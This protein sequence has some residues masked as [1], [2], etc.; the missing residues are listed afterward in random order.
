L[1]T[2]S[3]KF[4]AEFDC[5][6]DQFL[7]F[8]NE[9]LMQ[10]YERNIVVAIDE[11]E[12]SDKELD[13]FGSLLDQP[14][15]L[16]MMT[17][18]K[19][20]IQKVSSSWEASLGY[21]EGEMVGK[22]F[23]EFVHP[24]DIK[25][26]KHEVNLLAQGKSTLLFENR[27]I[28]KNGEELTLQ[29]AVIAVISEELV[30][31]FATD[32][33]ELKNTRNSMRRAIKL[34]EHSQVAAKVGGWELDIASGDLYWTDET[35]RIHDTSPEEFNP[36]VDAGVSYF[37]P[38]SKRIIS[39]AIQVAMESGVGYQ[40]DLQTYTTKGRLIDVY[41]TC[42]VTLENGR[43]SK[44][45][46]IFQDIT[47]RTKARTKLAKERSRLSAIF[48]SA[49]DG[50]ILIDSAGIVLSFN[51]AAES[52][53]KRTAEDVVGANVSLLM[54]DSI[55]GQHDGFLSNYLAGGAPGIIG[56]GREVIAQRSDG[57]HFPIELSITEWF[58]GEQRMFTGTVRDLSERKRIQSQLIQSQKMESLSQLSGGLAHDFNNLLNVVVGNLDLMEMSIDPSD[59]N[60]A[61]VQSAIRAVNRGADITNRM[62]HLSRL[63]FNQVGTNIAQDISHLLSEMVEILNQTLGAS[64]GVKYIKPVRPVYAKVDPAEFENAILNL[65]INARDAMTTGGEITIRLEVLQAA[66]HSDFGSNAEPG[67]KL[68]FID[69]GVGM[70]KDITEK[71]FEPFF[72][73][74]TGKG[75]GLGL[76]MVYNFVTGC[77]GK[78][79]VQSETGVG[80][81]FEIY[82]PLAEESTD[83]ME[84][85]RN[86]Q[87]IGGS[88]RVL[89]VDDEIDI[90][91][92]TQSH[93]LGLGYQVTTASNGFLAL[94]VLRK[95]NDFDLLLSDVT[96][97]GG[98]L[99]TEL[100]TRVQSLYPNIKVLLSSGFSRN[101][102]QDDKY[103]QFRNNILAKPYR[104]RSLAAAVRRALDQNEIYRSNSEFIDIP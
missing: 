55:G 59:P 18:M 3:S 4:V 75:S 20:V 89:L 91:T 38:E 58:D 9:Y 87:V 47:E 103:K 96:M 40:L 25:K 39:E 73:T 10:K 85:P 24:E 86:N 21:S 62:L 76:A 74:K 46:G 19:G 11:S 97:P 80:T 71:I 49:I 56:I 8:S 102:A 31:G 53:F 16:H 99:G 68:E 2:N 52:L 64:V 48:A 15:S 81:K 43:P 90:L 12:K 34:L 92:V 14:N 1:E 79:D 82:L 33:S 32:I 5:G 95:N 98:M 42:E 50:I 36:T 44:L 67:L 65:G 84:L 78:I 23:L 29:W 28:Q 7:S 13:L 66:E 37:L 69:N 93:L 88:E 63:Q 51:K 70:S 54:P 17:D 26:S 94:E 35:Y 83:E 104:R 61:R 57:S 77:K 41:T 60:Y 6:F 100:A 45:T 27:Y 101:I 72:S 22:A 30:Y